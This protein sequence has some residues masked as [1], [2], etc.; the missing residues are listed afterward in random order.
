MSTRK[1]VG[2]GT[3]ALCG[4]ALL[5]NGVADVGRAQDAGKLKPE[6]EPEA[7][8]SA[9]EAAPLV[10]AKAKIDL[11]KALEIAQAKSPKA[12]LIY[13]STVADS[14]LLLFVAYL[15]AGEKVFE[16]D[17]DA[18]SGSLLAF[19]EIA[20]DELEDLTS[21]KKALTASKLNLAQAIVSARTKV[22]GG[23][24]FEVGLALY[25]G[26]SII[27]VALLTGKTV[28]SVEIDAVNGKVLEVAAVK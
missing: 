28:T 6:P 12:R 1:C 10:L 26:K 9:Q 22:K 19:E 2:I 13:C 4:L 3:V 8:K 7:A 14:G 23:K 16:A 18:V 17:V 25:Q 24:P 20:G 21:V 5:W 27:E 15:V 11:G